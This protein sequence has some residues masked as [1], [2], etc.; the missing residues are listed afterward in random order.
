MLEK[1]KSC[2]VVLFLLPAAA[3]AFME[4]EETTGP[5][6]TEFCIQGMKSRS[7]DGIYFWCGALVYRYPDLMNGKSACEGGLWWLCDP[8]LTES[9]LLD[10]G[11]SL[12]DFKSG[13]VTI[14]DTGEDYFYFPLDKSENYLATTNAYAIE[15]AYDLGDSV[16]IESLPTDHGITITT[17]RLWA[18]PYNNNHPL[19]FDNYAPPAS[20]IFGGGEP[21]PPPPPVPNCN[22]VDDTDIQVMKP[23][24]MEIGGR[25]WIARV[26]YGRAIDMSDEF[27]AEG[28]GVPGQDF[29]DRLLNRLGCSKLLGEDGSAVGSDQVYVVDRK[30][31]LGPEGC[32]PPCEPGYFQGWGDH[33]PKDDQDRLRER[34]LRND[35]VGYYL[36]M[37]PIPDHCLALEKSS[38]PKDE[39]SNGKAKEAPE[40]QDAAL[41]DHG[42]GDCF[43]GS[44]SVSCG[45]TFDGGQAAFG[46]RGEFSTEDEP[47]SFDF[48][49][50]I[51]GDYSFFKSQCAKA[52]NILSMDVDGSCGT[53][54]NTG[55]LCSPVH[56]CT[57]TVKVKTR[58]TCKFPT[59]N[60]IN[61][62]DEPPYPSGV[63][64][65]KSV[66]GREMIGTLCDPLCI[67]TTDNVTSSGGH[68]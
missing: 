45:F 20:C 47:P 63:T 48:D 65:F 61:N 11:E 1:L 12:R 50:K 34:I 16:S 60:Y 43:V 18:L 54:C 67:A 49:S 31:V 13:E 33:D 27:T 8:S 15:N 25:K 26:K 64:L 51:Q 57:Y 22:G 29:A 2:L 28:R 9:I 42:D 10:I 68:P 41:A 7:G 44:R 3:G 55:G 6:S 66:S 62:F 23:F 46:V 52:S 35:Q 53:S 17:A 4:I 56:P 24:E 39:P 19:P 14:L 36:E 59:C 5:C 30:N 21:P 58:E 32:V 38:A 37:R 40:V